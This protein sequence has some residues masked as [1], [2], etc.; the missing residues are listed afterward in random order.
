[1]TWWQALAK[2]GTMAFDRHANRS[3]ASR[4][5]GHNKEMYQMSRADYLAD[6]KYDEQYLSRLVAGAKDAGLHPLAALGVNPAGGKTF[7]ASG[8]NASSYP[9]QSGDIDISASR[10]NDAQIRNLDAQ[11]DQI[12]AQTAATK[13]A[14]TK[15]AMLSNKDNYHDLERPQRTTHIDPAGVP[16]DTFDS[17]DANTLEDRYGELGG[18]ILG[19]ANI[20]LDVAQTLYNVLK[21]KLGTDKRKSRNRRWR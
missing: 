8:G 11:T 16:L 3:S 5:Y 1:M 12:R 20:P 9:T 6:R 21:R 10:V 4:A 7:V 14:L 17:V 13:L 2:A 18:S 15:N 19:L